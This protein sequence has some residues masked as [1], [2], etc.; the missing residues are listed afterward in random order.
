MLSGPGKSDRRCQILW[1]EQRYHSSWRISSNINFN[2][3]IIN[4]S[5][6]FVYFM[7]YDFVGNS[8][9]TSRFAFCP[10]FRQ[11]NFQFL[12]FQFSLC[13]LQLLQLYECGC[14]QTGRMYHQSLQKLS[15]YKRPLNICVCS[16]VQWSWK[17]QQKMSDIVARVEISQQSNINFNISMMNIPQISVFFM[18]YDFIGKL[19][20]LNLDKLIS[21]SWFFSFPYAT[22]NCCSC[23]NVV[24]LGAAKQTGRMHHQSLE[25]QACCAGCRHRPFPMK[26]HQ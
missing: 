20:V 21:G 2:I 9:N 11:A 10:Q 25:K 8:C 5:Q 22:H 14:T 16:Y 12:A 6:I 17:S 7:V 15:P 19:N 18:V 1:Q 23:M 26:L 4:I 24:V 13:Y 3:S